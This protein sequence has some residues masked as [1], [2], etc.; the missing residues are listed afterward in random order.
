MFTGIV[1]TTGTVKEIATS[2]GNKTFWIQSEISHGF[3]A[4][5]S[6]SHNGVCLTVE[7]TTDS[8]HRV[9]AIRET[10]A[11]SN[12]GRLQPGNVVNLEQSLKLEARLDGHLVQG[13]VD[14]TA[15]CLRKT[16][17]K[18]SWEYEFSF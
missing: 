1:E 9:T 17:K 3:R 2:G 16:E 18:G 14:A 13:H 5:Q 8:A 11:K 10:L 15:V 6:V 4:D 7:E 12:L